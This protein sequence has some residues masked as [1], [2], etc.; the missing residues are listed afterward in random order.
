MHFTHHPFFSNSYNNITR[1]NTALKS[2]AVSVH[3]GYQQPL[4][5]WKPIS[6]NELLR[7]GCKFHAWI[8]VEHYYTAGEQLRYDFFNS[9]TWNCKTKANK[10]GACTSCIDERIHPDNL[11]ITVQKWST[12]ISSIY[13]GISLNHVNK[14]ARIIRI[15]PKVSILSTHNTY[16]N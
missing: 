11:S 7:H 10:S 16:C 6:V 2:R 5:I 4:N 9:V 15:G 14:Y 8:V 13:R 1:K 12:G 3:T